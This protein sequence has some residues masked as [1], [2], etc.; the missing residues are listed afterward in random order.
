L[1]GRLVP[2]NGSESELSVIGQLFTQYIN[3]D[4]S[5]VI[6]QGVS[7]LQNDNTNISWLSEGVQALRLDV[8]FKSPTPIN[9]IQSIDIGSLSLAFSEAQPWAPVA[10]SR[11]VHAS[12]R[13]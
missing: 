3:S 10:N 9:P 6:A 4:T 8:P 13:A 2:H 7:T 12:M 1:L 11:S 5:P